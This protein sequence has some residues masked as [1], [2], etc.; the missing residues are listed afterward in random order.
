MEPLSSKI[1]RG[2]VYHER[3]HPK[4]HVFTYPVTFFA[5]DLKELETLAHNSLLFGYN[6]FRPLSIYDTDYL[7]GRTQT[8][9]KQIEALLTP[10]KKDETHLLVTCPRF[11]GLAFNPVNFHFRLQD[12]QLQAAIAEVNNTFR[13]RHV[14]PLH[15]FEN[16]TQNTWL[17]ETPKRFHV[18]PFNDL[19]G[20]YHFSFKIKPNSLNL[21]VDLH[22]EG[23]CVMKTALSGKGHSITAR[24]LW[25]Y[26]LLNPADTALNSF[27]R[28]L[29][30]AAKIAYKRKLPVYKRPI[31]E[32]P[33]TLLRRED[34]DQPPS[35]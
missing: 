21:G 34:R 3:L 14:Y 31:P 1:F 24:N 6:N 19:A 20:N 17:S 10:A 28:I 27:P 16:P 8:I 9:L 25:K 2:Q 23:R 26:F 35:I 30:Q 32:N 11:L 18:S 13:D 29:W 4:P 33:N 12:N 7:H 15:T 22:R 5:F